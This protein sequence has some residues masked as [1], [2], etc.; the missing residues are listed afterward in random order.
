M[1]MKDFFFRPQFLLF[2]VIFLNIDML[3]TGDLSY[4]LTN[5]NSKS[6]FS[7]CIS[8]I[9]K[10]CHGHN[11]SE[12]RETIYRL[13]NKKNIHRPVKVHYDEDEN[14]LNSTSNWRSQQSGA[15]TTGVRPRAQKKDHQNRR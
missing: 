10:G 11:G 7:G 14:G 6:L 5:V 1:S 9:G 12:T 8:N 15:S 2:S 3:L 4:I 13:T